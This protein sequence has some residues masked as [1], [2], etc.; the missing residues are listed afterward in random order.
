MDYTIIGGQ[1]NIAARR[2]KIADPDSIC[3]SEFT[4]ALV[5]DDVEVDGPRMV[6]VRGIHFPVKVYRIIGLRPG[7]G[8]RM[9]PYVEMGNG[10]LMRQFSYEPGTATPAEKA[11]LLEDLKKAA[12]FIAES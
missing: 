8:A 4:Y 1:V 5:K 10:F 2:E 3:I 9:S 6:S 12:R 11:S 7:D